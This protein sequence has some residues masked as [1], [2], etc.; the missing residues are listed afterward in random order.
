MTTETNEKILAMYQ[1]VCAL[2]EEGYDT[3]KMKVA[4][5][6]SRAGI[7]KGTA[8]EYFR[9]K[10][11][12][13]IKA[14]QYDFFAGYQILE[15]ELKS[16]KTFQDTVEAAF[17]WIEQNMQKK[18]LAMQC[19]KILE[20]FR[21][22]NEDGTE[23]CVKER[24]VQGVGLFTELLDYMIE[25]GKKE[26][27][28]NEQVPKELARLEIGSKFMGYYLFLQTS[29]AEEADLRQTKDFLYGNMVKS[30]K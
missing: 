20:K 24:M 6:T 15:K 2:I 21:K 17:S 10:D 25:I 16:R 11:E 7:G 9:S 26:S 1:A 14:L 12:L 23:D 8:Y 4:D 27:C 22:K 18:R 28:I 5:I 29:G 13:L 30:L 19:L 3:H